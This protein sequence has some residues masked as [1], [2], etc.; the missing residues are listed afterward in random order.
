M[1]PQTIIAALPWV[2]RGWKLL[3]PQAR[4]FVLV[5]AAGI[6]IWYAVSGREQLAE[7]RDRNEG[8]AAPATT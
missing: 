6:G 2:R 4:P 5:I 8:E 3:P 7:A 1:D